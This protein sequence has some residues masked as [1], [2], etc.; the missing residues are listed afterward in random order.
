L[1]IRE[2]TLCNVLHHIHTQIFGYALHKSVDIITN[3][4]E[5]G[6]HALGIFIDLSKAFVT[7]DHQ[8]L[9]S[10]LENYGVRGAA[11]ALL[12]SYSTERSQHVPFCKTSSDPLAIKYGVPQGSIIYW[13]LFFFFFM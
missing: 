7:L 6:K 1:S 8:T 5:R 2:V 4:R 3:A 12:T 9:V 10:K 11:L 13:A